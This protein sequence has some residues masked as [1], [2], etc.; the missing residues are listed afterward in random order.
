MSAS[1]GFGAA[2][3]NDAPVSFSRTRNASA[4][5]ALSN[6]EFFANPALR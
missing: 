6:G 1:Q 5:A 4:K 2:S 3:L